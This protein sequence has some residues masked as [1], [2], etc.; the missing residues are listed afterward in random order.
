MAKGSSARFMSGYGWVIDRILVDTMKIRLIVALTVLAIDFAALTSA[1]Q[2]IMIDQKIVDQV[3][4]LATKYVEAYNRRDPAALAALYA[5]HGRRV[6][7]YGTFYGRPAIEKSY[8]K[9]DFQIW[10]ATDMFKRI[11]RII[12]VG[13]EIHAYGIWSCSFQDVGYPVVGPNRVD[14]GHFS[15]VLVPDVDTLKIARETNSESNM[16]ANAD[17]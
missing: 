4:A 17:D 6:T 10:H 3:R 8:A 15:W 2:N 1:Q 14:E 13:N 12:A 5:E 11:D 7:R 9:Y 16:H